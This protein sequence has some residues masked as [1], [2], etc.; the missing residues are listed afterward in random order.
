[1]KKKINEKIIFIGDLH[2]K[3]IWEDI[4]KKEIFFDKIIFIGDY[5][6]CFENI[7][8]IK[9]IENFENICKFKN[10]YPNKVI[11]LIGNHDGYNIEE[12]QQYTIS[13]YQKENAFLISAA[14]DKYKHLLQISYSLHNNILI[15]H[16]GVTRTFLK[17]I[18]YPDLRK[19]NATKINN[20]LNDKW[21][22]APKV[23]KFFGKDRYGQ[24]ITQS[25]IWVRPLSLEKDS[26]G[27]MFHQIVGHTGVKNIRFF[28]NYKYNWI[29][30]DT[31]DSCSEYLVYNNNSFLIKTL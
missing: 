11:I 3:T 25:C 27:C 13:G 31:F 24:D 10:K 16:A 6:D 7:S 17:R 30:I 8:T 2:G 4:I 22:Y 20:F 26:R 29:Y 1:M 9:Q 18:G 14:L 5:F 12:L 19:M 21:K 28:K 15:T 23:F